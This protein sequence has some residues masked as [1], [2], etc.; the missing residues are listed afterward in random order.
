MPAPEPAFSY[1]TFSRFVEVFPVGSGLLVVW[2]RYED[3]GATRLVAGQRVYADL[4]GVRS[5]LQAAVFDLTKDQGLVQEAL[6][7]FDRSSWV[8]SMQGDHT[9]M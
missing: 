3:Q 5:R 8:A 1:R 7:L 4:I 9:R 2:G 6:T